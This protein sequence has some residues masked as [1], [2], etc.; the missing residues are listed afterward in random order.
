[1]LV[2]ALLKFAAITFA[3]SLLVAGC[4]ILTRP[5]EKSGWNI[6]FDGKSTDASRGGRESSV[7]IRL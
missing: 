6:L 3:F 7:S 2:K 1:V 4:S 5:E